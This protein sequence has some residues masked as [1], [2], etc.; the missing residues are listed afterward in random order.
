MSLNIEKTILCIDFGTSESKMAWYNPKTKQAEIIKNAEG[1][2]HTPS[3]VYYGKRETLVGKAAQNMLEDEQEQQYVITSVKRKMTQSDTITLPDGRAIPCTEV[4]SEI[5]SK[6]KHDAEQG[7]FHETV[8]QVV[9][10]YPTSFPT[11]LQLQLRDAAE[12]AGF[13]P[14][15]IKLIQEPVAAALA[16]ALQGHNVGNTILV[17][18]F[19]G[20]TFDLALLKRQTNNLLQPVLSLG[21]EQCGGDDL[22]LALYN[23]YDQLAHTEL[24]RG[25]S[26]TDE[27]DAHFLHACREQK[28]ALTLNDQHKFTALLEPG[29]VVFRPQIE[30][31]T[32]EDLA[33]PIIQNTVRQ[34][35]ELLDRAATEG[36]IVETV[37]MVGG[38]SS[39]PLVEQLLS[40]NITVKVERWQYNKEAVA[41]GAAYYGI[42]PIKPQIPP[43]MPP[44]KEIIKPPTPQDTDKTP[45]PKPTLNSIS[46]P[47]K[48]RHL[49]VVLGV[50]FAGIAILAVI[51]G[52]FYPIIYNAILQSNINATAQAN[53][54]NATATAQVNEANA[55]ATAT[56][57]AQQPISTTPS[58]SGGGCC[59]SGALFIPMV[60]GLIGIV[61]KL[62]FR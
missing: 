18:D 45:T 27:P 11:D 31:T 47:S 36:Y 59:T 35:Q 34:T 12:L 22:D 48:R 1:E 28:E 17:Y 20:G 13:A 62:R 50:I 58:S 3:I 52:V 51:V 4:I 14:D 19:G 21:I 39:V 55:N 23:H 41:L 53:N 24:D 29:P 42:E 16:F 2:E 25:I 33:Q 37:L 56:A 26:L 49:G 54:N 61:S 7:H 8:T 40:R 32:F 9:I 44:K 5:L 60:A 30:R 10:T 57:I 6:L 43:D 46:S 38:S 15:A